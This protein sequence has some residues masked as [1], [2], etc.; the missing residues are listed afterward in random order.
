MTMMATAAMASADTVRLETPR[1]SCEIA[2]MGAR[3]MSFKVD[4]RETFF[5]PRQ[6][7]NDGTAFSHGGIPLCWPW[8][9]SS[10]PEGSKKHG[11]AYSL[12]FKVVER[13]A[14]NVV[15]AARSSPA[16]LA[17]WPHD[18]TL[19]YSV[20]LEE[21]ALSVKLETTNVSPETFMLTC[22][23]H[24]Y[25]ALADRDKATVK[26]L[27]GRAYCD[28]RVTTSFDSTW[29]GDLAVTS[30]FDHVFASPDGEYNLLD[31]ASGY[32]VTISA[33]GNRRIVV[34]NPGKDR[35]TEDPPPPG[36]VGPGDWRHLVCVEP[37]TLWKDQAF[38]I[39]PGGK[40][41]H[42][43]KIRVSGPR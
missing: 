19:E 32:T 23:F 30:S 28:S 11:F 7:K 26:G 5:A 15:L 41:V 43:M 20:T 6:W 2:C 17:L 21:D 4:G 37:A 36:A 33:K 13:S 31:G 39:P 42:S 27:D 34:W 24:P 12:E 38:A 14:T 22:G 18:F 16:T 9:G 8:F 25:F 10:G 29:K 40:N 35:P 1:S 3:V